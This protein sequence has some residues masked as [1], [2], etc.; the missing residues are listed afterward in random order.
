MELSEVNKFVAETASETIDSQISEMVWK[1]KRLAENREDLV[2]RMKFNGPYSFNMAGI[3]ATGVYFVVHKDTKEV[4]YV[5]Q[6]KVNGR[7]SRIKSVMRNG[8]RTIISASGAASGHQGATKMYQID[9]KLSN[10]QYYEMTCDKDTA[11]RL[12]A[13]LHGLLSPSCSTEHMVGVN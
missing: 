4:A 12:E 9:P 5:G 10:W 13:K 3:Q 1:I 7:I 11:V 8:G 2:E 6:G